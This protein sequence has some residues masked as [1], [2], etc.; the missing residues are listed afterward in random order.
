MIDFVKRLIPQEWMPRVPMKRIIMHWTA[1][2]Y[3]PRPDEMQ[4]YTAVMDGSGQW[5]K[6]VDL[7]LQ[8]KINRNQFY[9]A[10]TLNCNE[11][12]IGL[13]MACA[14][15]AEELPNGAKWGPCPPT[16]QMYDEFIKGV[17]EYA[18]AYNIPITY[19]TVLSHAEVQGNLG[20][21]QRGKWDFTRFP[22]TNVRGARAIGDM[23]RR[24]ILALRN[25]EKPVTETV[26]E[27]LNTKKAEVAVPT[28][29]G[30]AGYAASS[31]GDD[32]L[33]AVPDPTAVPGD[34]YSDL[35]NQVSTIAA[36]GFSWGGKLLM[37]LTLG[38]ALWTAFKYARFAWRYY[39]PPKP[40]AAERA[41]GVD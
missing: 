40:N 16:K 35:T 11:G 20:I 17:N 37:A 41:R 8:W 25:E 19:K 9:A 33:H 34:W 1:G 36:Y 22:W 27:A 13:S 6:G 31:Q 3:V 7:T 21:P 39:F 14:A 32:M 29:T 38:I 23:I 5:H 30:I 12:S 28:T 18:L 10:H 26:A 2:H 15:L 24:D 4:H